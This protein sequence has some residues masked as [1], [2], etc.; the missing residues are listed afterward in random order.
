MRD[1]AR[2]RS[3]ASNPNHCSLNM[4]Y[5]FDE[6]RWESSSKTPLTAHLTTKYNLFTSHLFYNSRILWSSTT[7]LK[8]S[9]IRFR[10]HNDIFEL[11]VLL[12]DVTLPLM[13]FR[14]KCFISKFFWELCVWVKSE[15]HFLQHMIYF[16]IFV[17]QSL[18]EITVFAETFHQTVDFGDVTSSDIVLNF[19][20]SECP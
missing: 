7:S 1:G 20:F 2:A 12:L 11:V 9:T 8:N 5:E 19:V 15:M 13:F 10:I 6:M 3:R 17:A 18:V 16:F 4:N 14:T